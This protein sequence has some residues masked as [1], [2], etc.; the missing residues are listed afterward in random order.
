MAEIRIREFEYPADYNAALRLWDS[1]GPG[2]H[3][4]PSDTPLELEKKLRRDPDLFL[5]AVDEDVLIGTVIGGFDGR[6]GMVYHLAVAEQYRRAGIAS[7]L[8]SAVEAR[9]RAK[10]CIKCYLL[11][12]PENRSAM[13]YYKAIGWSLSDNLIFMKE[14][15]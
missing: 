13:E 8:M 9:L 12:R 10:G 14:F 3:V 2:V 11:V 4:G 1:A 6:R 5:V 7:R 15:A